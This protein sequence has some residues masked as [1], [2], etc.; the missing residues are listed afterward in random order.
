M[1]EAEALYCRAIEI[2]QKSVSGPK[3]TVRDLMAYKSNLAELWEKMGHVEK[4]LLLRQN[5]LA[6]SGGGQHPT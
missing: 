4:A 3:Q 6:T 5:I 2:V 1:D